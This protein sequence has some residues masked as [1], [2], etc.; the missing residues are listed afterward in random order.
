M[1]VKFLKNNRTWAVRYDLTSIPKLNET[2]LM[3]D[4]H[5]YKVT[6]VSWD[7]SNIEESIAVVRL[8]LPKLKQPNR[9][10]RVPKLAKA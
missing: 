7:L 5:L 1:K 3:A 2:V 10:S 4:D 6:D 9:K 8:E